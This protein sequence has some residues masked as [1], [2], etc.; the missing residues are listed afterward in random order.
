MIFLHLAV[1]AAAGD[2]IWVGRTE[3]EAQNIIR[4]FQLQ[5]QRKQRADGFRSKQLF[6]SCL[7]NVASSDDTFHTESHISF[8]LNSAPEILKQ[9]LYTEHDIFI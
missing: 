6:C 3:L 9:L 5:L 2:D 4:T 7:Q 1:H 8:M